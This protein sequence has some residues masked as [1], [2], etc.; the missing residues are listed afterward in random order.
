MNIEEQRA[1]LLGSFLL[2]TQ[3]FYKLRTGRDFVISSPASRESHYIAIG[4]TL[5]RVLRCDLTR[6]IIN[7]P[8]RYG[9]TELLIHFIAWSLA[10]YPD[11]NFIYVSYSHSLAK[12]Q[13]QTIREIINLPEYK[14]LFHVELKDD[15]AAKDNFETTANGSVYAVG[16]GGT[17]TGRGAGIQN[18]EHFSGCIVIDDIHKPT[19][20]T[21]D[22]MR[23]EVNNWFLNTLQSRV[24]SSSVPIIFIG[25]RLHEDDL[26]ANLIKGFDGNKWELMSLKALDDARNALLPTMHSKEQLLKMQE[27]MPYEFSA[28]YQQDPQP[29]GGGIFKPEWFVMLDEEPKILA[30]FIVADT[31]ETSKDYNDAT[32]FS[33]FGIYK[34]EIVG[35]VTDLFG[36]HWID[37]V[38][39]RVEPKDLQSEFMHFWASCM[40]HAVK[41]EIAAIE[42]KSTGTTLLS[43]IKSV[44][45]IQALQIERTRESGSKTSRFLSAQPFVANKQVSLP[46]YGKHTQMCIEHM[47]K[48]TANNSH[49]FDD[50]ADTLA[51]GIDLG[52]ANKSIP[53]SKENKVDEI[54]SRLAAQ[55][56]RQQNLGMGSWRG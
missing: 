29:A 21:S 50:I 32:V 36:L 43:V 40:R 22:T 20:V 10:H 41:P 19:E 18:C 14:R 25:Q 23:A 46:S 26:A 31:A 15:V 49:R 2:F 33:F 13:T 27:V 35:V 55:N 11:S 28:Q 3:V 9:K 52:L 38:E 56:K 7:V 48:I 17:I 5:T 42:K 54:V 12:K 6:L 8:P 47:R 37:C 34:I 1:K 53:I 24:N 4:K 51:D 16:A 45:G 30:T 44:Q 39:L